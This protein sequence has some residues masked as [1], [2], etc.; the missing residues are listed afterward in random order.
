MALMPVHQGDL[1][2]VRGRPGV[3]RVARVRRGAV[4]VA[5]VSLDVTATAVTVAVHD[6]EVWSPEE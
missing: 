5:S 2:T 4:W 6:V 3:W 1:V